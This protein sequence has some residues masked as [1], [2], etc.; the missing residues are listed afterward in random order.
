[1]LVALLV[2]P[3]WSDRAVGQ[4]ASATNPPRTPADSQAP[5][6]DQQDQ[7]PDRSHLGAVPPRDVWDRLGRASDHL[8]LGVPDCADRTEFLPV[9]ARIALRPGPMR[10]V[11]PRREMLV[12]IASHWPCGPPCRF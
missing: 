11:L 7:E 12:G 8:Q 5:Q 3:L 4:D 1:V 2:A 6:P 9:P 10:T